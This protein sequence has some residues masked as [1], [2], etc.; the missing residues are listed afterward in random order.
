MA[1]VSVVQREIVFQEYGIANTRPEDHEIDYLMAPL[2]RNRR[3]RQS[4]ARI[5]GHV[6]GTLLSV[7]GD[8]KW[9][10]S[11]AVNDRGVT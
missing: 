7:H 5:T 6:S 11:W 9:K 8:Q 1:D 4:L 3:H 2:R 10:L